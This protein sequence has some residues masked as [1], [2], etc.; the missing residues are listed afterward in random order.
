MVAGLLPPD[1]G[2]IE[3]FGVDTLADPIAAKRDH[4][5]AA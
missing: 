3:I 5:M 4:G 2:S 1:A